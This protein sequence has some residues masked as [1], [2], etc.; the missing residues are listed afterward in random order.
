M[1]GTP[2]HPLRP[3]RR[4]PYSDQ[5]HG[6]HILPLLLTIVAAAGSYLEEA[7]TPDIQDLSPSAGFGGWSGPPMGHYLI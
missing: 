2:L 3:S 5:E 7:I 4:E 6:G 1:G